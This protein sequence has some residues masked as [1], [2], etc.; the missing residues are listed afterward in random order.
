MAVKNGTIEGERANPVVTI[1]WITLAEISYPAVGHTIIANHYYS[2]YLE[3][4]EHFLLVPKALKKRF[5]R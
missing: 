5:S 4:L 2:S 1:Y 3:Y